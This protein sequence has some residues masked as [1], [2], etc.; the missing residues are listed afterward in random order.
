MLYSSPVGIKH[1][2]ILCAISC[3][4]SH[5]CHRG[6]VFSPHIQF[7]GCRGLCCSL[8][9]GEVLYLSSLCILD[10]LLSRFMNSDN[11]GRLLQK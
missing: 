10:S 7:L 4:M 9:Q 3:K 11:Y 1:Q 8:S 6:T 2:S 5:G